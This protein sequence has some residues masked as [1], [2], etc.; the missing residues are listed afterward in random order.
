[1]AFG[2]HADRFGW[3]AARRRRVLEQ[4]E[5][6]QARESEAARERLLRHAAGAEHRLAA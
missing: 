4:A 2:E 1:M 3:A 5:R 6:E